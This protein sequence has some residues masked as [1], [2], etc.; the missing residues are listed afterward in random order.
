MT[1]GKSGKKT[2]FPFCRNKEELKKY[3][4]IQSKR[5]GKNYIFLIDIPERPGK[6]FMK[7]FL[8]GHNFQYG[9]RNG[10]RLHAR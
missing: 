1:N 4:I 7:L 6:G 3:K 8:N 5:I 9:G 2:A 10:K